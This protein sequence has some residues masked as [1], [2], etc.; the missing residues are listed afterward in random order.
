MPSST[1]LTKQS[2]HCSSAWCMHACTQQ[3]VDR[4]SPSVR[5]SD[6]FVNLDLC[7][8]DGFLLWSLDT[9][10]GSFFSLPQLAFDLTST[11]T[12]HD[13]SGLCSFR[14]FARFCICMG[15]RVTVHKQS[16]TN[17]HLHLC[18]GVGFVMFVPRA[19]TIFD[20]WLTGD[21]TGEHAHDAQRF[22]FKFSK[23]STVIKCRCLC[24]TKVL[25]FCELDPGS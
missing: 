7:V 23:T 3:F 19:Q 4:T 12:M 14:T 10:I 9:S 16:K 5:L 18:Q 11:P 24:P 21:H 17:R 20:Q 13:S 22:V 6:S 8:Q 15:T 25:S 1:L 2:M